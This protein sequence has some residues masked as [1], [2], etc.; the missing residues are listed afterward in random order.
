[1]D[2]VASSTYVEKSEVVAT[3][4]ARELH[5]R[6]EWVDREFPAL[7]DIFKNA[8]LLRTLGIDAA[9][10]STRIGP[11]REVASEQSHG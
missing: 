2:D 6:A 3:L 11:G 8:A 7:I 9:A 1:V 5:G 10:M 4:R